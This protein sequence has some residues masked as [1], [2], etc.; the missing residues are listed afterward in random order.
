MCELS[1]EKKRSLRNQALLWDMIA[2]KG[3]TAIE[4]SGWLRSFDQKPFTEKEMTEFTENVFTKLQ[5]PYLNSGSASIL[6]IGVGSGQILRRLASHTSTYTATDIT[7]SILDTCHRFT[8]ENLAAVEYRKCFAHEIGQLPEDYDV[9]IMNSIM[10]YFGDLEYAMTVLRSCRQKIRAKGVLFCGDIMD[11]DKRK[12]LETYILAHSLGPVKL[13]HDKL[14]FYKKSFFK[15][16]ADL[17]GFSQCSIS[18]K[19]Y[20]IANEL[21][22]FRFDALLYLG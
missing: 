12:A 9:I 16:A 15:E 4:S 18:D 1:P 10:Q 14:L 2:R 20:T 17:V 6:E 7:D 21:S 3:Q 19:T 8:L 5:T 22:L 13:N 11:E